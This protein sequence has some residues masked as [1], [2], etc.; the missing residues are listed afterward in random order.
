M[1]KNGE[2][3]NYWKEERYGY[4]KK[5]IRIIDTQQAKIKAW[6]ENNI[7]EAWLKKPKWIHTLIEAWRTEVTK[8]SQHLE[9]GS[10]QKDQGTRR[11]RES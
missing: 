2:I 3:T 4:W 8:K 5:K 6:L 7:R 9:K 10:K 11:E 1:E